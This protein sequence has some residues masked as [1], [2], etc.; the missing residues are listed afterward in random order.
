MTIIKSDVVGAAALDKYDLVKTSGAL[1]VSAASTDDCVGIVQDGA[2]IGAT[3]AIC[4]GGATKA[5]AGAA[6]SKFDLLEAAADGEVVT[7]STT[8]TKPIIG[9]ALEAAGAQGDLIEIN[10]TNDG[11]GYAA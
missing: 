9:R 7:H 6:I 1:V 2:A 10:L 8:S 5:R 4:L 11:S 3:V